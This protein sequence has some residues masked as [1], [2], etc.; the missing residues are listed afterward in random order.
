MQRPV[1]SKVKERPTLAGG[2]S[3]GPPARAGRV[4]GQQGAAE[5]WGAGLQFRLSR[6]PPAG[7]AAPSGGLFPR[8]YDRAPPN[9][10]LGDPGGK[11][12]D[13]TYRRISCLVRNVKS[14]KAE[15]DWGSAGRPEIVPALPPAPG[16]RSRAQAR[17]QAPRGPASRAPGTRPAAPWTGGCPNPPSLRRA[18]FRQL[19]SGRRQ[20]SHFRPR[21][22]SPPDPRDNRSW[23]H[24][25][26]ARPVSLTRPGIPS[27]VQLPAPGSGRSLVS[28]RRGP[29]RGR[30]LRGGAQAS[31]PRLR[32]WAERATPLACVQAAHASKAPRP[33]NGCG[34]SL[35]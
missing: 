10:S 8:R 6:R 32:G 25:P 2:S 22:A 11:V 12:R 17:A 24:R 35:G 5:G 34:R 16:P 14:W 23:G 13:S 29:G 33:R 1:E 26:R 9:P 27:W 4:C 18:Q 30:P 28:W 7:P 15:Q 21:A 3:A 20:L 19:V 31:R